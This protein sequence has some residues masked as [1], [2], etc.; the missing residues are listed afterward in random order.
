MR[1]LYVAKGSMGI[2][3]IIV[4][5]I[6]CVGPLCL[7]MGINMSMLGITESVRTIGI[8]NSVFNL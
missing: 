3:T 8:F 6:E 4:I 1:S 5:M 2:K 7:R